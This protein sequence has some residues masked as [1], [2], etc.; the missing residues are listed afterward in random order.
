MNTMFKQKFAYKKVE[1]HYVSHFIFFSWVLSYLHILDRATHKAIMCTCET[2][3]HL[4]LYA[5]FISLSLFV[6]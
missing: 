1:E 3:I 5:M 2:K 4:T 6:L